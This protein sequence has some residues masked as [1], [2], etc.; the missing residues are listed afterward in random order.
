MLNIN[1]KNDLMKKFIMREH[2]IMDLII[3][4]EFKKLLNDYDKITERYYLKYI[5]VKYE[6]NYKNFKELINELFATERSAANNK[7]GGSC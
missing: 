3:N 1:K 5:N 2:E 4:I 6:K 7:P